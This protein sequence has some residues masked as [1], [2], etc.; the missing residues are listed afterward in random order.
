MATKLIYFVR[1][2]ETENNAQNIRQGPEGPL[3]EKGREQALATAKRFPKHKGRP[4]VIIASPYERAKETANIIAE[5]LKMPVEYLDLL[6]ERKNPT[7]IIGRQGGERDIR[8]IID[9][10]DKSYHA[11]DL[12]YSDEENFIDLKERAKKLLAYIVERPEKRMIM[13]TH[14]IFL[15]MVVS[16]MLYGDKLTAS[17][18]NKLSYFNPIDNAGMAICSYTSHWFKKSEWKIIV[19]NDLD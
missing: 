5:E 1:H 11:D 4:Q 12:R 8:R 16:Y 10:I 9:R 19:W 17:E 15:K 6:V 14:G 18:Y 7:E 2:G 13:V 3:T